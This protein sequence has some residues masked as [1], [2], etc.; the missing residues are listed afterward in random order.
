MS[1]LDYIKRFSKITITK[2]CNDNHVDRSNLLAGRVKDKK[3]KMIRKAIEMEIGNI[4][5]EE[6]ESIKE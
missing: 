3:V 6:Y 5:K 4:Y 1:D 2:V